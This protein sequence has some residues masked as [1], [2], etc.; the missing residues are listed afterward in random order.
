MAYFSLT[1]GGSSTAQREEARPSA[2]GEARPNEKVKNNDGEKLGGHALRPQAMSINTLIQRWKRSRP[3]ETTGVETSEREEVRRPRYPRFDWPPAPWQERREKL[4]KERA[5]KVRAT[6]EEPKTPER[7]KS[8][9]PRTSERV[10]F[11]A[12]NPP[13][14]PP[15]EHLLRPQEK[16]GAMR[17]E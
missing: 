1:C 15:P 2:R 7:V 9:P 8:A 14:T 10:K 6:R 4:R 5:E 17:A 12:P 11:R 3:G 16:K 13:T